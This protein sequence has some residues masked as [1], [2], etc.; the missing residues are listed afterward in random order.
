M[1]YPV[2]L[3]DEAHQKTDSDTSGCG[4]SFGK[5]PPV[6]NCCLCSKDML[7]Q[8]SP[9]NYGQDDHEFKQLAV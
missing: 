6:C 7:S 8:L 4:K 3:A 1:G 5:Y 2:N 9:E